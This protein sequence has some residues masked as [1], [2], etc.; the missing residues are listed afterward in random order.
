MVS[1][2]PIGGTASGGGQLPDSW[3]NRGVIQWRS[4]MQKTVWLSTAK[5]ENHLASKMA[6]EILYLRNL[7]EKLG[8]MQAPNTP[9]YEDNAACIEWGNHLIGG[10][11]RAKHI[12]IRKHLAHETIQNSKMR[13]IKVDTSG[14]I[15]DI[16]TK[17]LQLQQFLTCR[18]G[19]LIS[20][21]AL[22]LQGGQE[23]SIIAGARKDA[24]DIGLQSIEPRWPF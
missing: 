10:R 12:D 5:A 15:A 13:L 24:E 7:L 19:V 11:E 20:E 6:I 14:H 3:F 23:V 1:Q 2:P 21:R 9:V 17:L 16:F 4:K 18:G 22:R 8:F